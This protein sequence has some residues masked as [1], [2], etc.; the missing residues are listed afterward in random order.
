MLFKS[1]GERNRV[2]KDIQT[3]KYLGTFYITNERVVLKCK[4]SKYSFDLTLDV[5]SNITTDYDHI[6]IESDEKTWFLLS[7]DSVYIRDLIELMNICYEE[8]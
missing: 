8:Q 3:N 1:I 2:I 7:E 6:I 5:L 4:N